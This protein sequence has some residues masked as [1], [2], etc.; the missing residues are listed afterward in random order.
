[1]LEIRRCGLVEEGAEALL[2]FQRTCAVP[3]QLCLRFLSVDQDLISSA[4]AP[5]PACPP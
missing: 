3:V 5:A 2:R 4:I 1:M